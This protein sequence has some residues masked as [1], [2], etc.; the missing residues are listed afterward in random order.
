MQS[1]GDH[2]LMAAIVLGMQFRHLDPSLHKTL[3]F[4][5]IHLLIA[6]SVG[7]LFTGSFVL[8]GLLS[9]TEPALNTVAHHQLDRWWDRRAPRARHAA[10]YKTLVFGAIHMAIA[11]A[12]GGWLTGSFVLATAYAF[13]EPA[14]NAVAH[15][16]FERWWVRPQTRATPGLASA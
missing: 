13:V 16:F 9:L 2:Q 7:W 3:S 6:V 12:L 1:T 14:V 11:V 5:S 15:Y 4:G 8:A 10:L